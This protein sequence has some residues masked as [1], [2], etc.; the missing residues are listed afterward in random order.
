MLVDRAEADPVETDTWLELD[1][2]LL[3]TVLL[4][5]LPL[6]PFEATSTRTDRWLD[7]VWPSP[8]SSVTV[9]LKTSV[10]T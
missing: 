1:E 2:L 3:E 9:S 5:A 6:V 10:T 8:E 7:F 4:D